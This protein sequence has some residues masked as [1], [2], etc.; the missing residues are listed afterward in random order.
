[1]L[2]VER[3]PNF[4]PTIV[5]LTRISTTFEKVL[6]SPDK[7][8]SNEDIYNLPRKVVPYTASGRE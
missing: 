8:C 3:I 1:M 7:T 4:P 2:A 6:D 5:T